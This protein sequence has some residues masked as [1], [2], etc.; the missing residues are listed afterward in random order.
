MSIINPIT[1]KIAP[2]SEI[3]KMI[4]YRRPLHPEMFKLRARRLDRHNGYEAESWIVDGGH[5]LRFQFGNTHLAE[6]CMENCDHL[7]EAGMLHA[8]PCIGERDYE[9]EPVGQGSQRVGYITSLQ[10]ENLSENLYAATYREMCEFAQEAEAIHWLWDSQ[11]G[12]NLSV[13]D[14]QKY[15]SEYHVQTYHLTAKGGN[16]LRTQT[17]FELAK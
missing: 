4:V 2:I 3:P 13:V 8:L 17:V 16:V 9:H 14:V 1:N 7:P 6:V 5:V 11:H 10:T 12:K 15:R